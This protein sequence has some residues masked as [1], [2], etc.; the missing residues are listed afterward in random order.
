[1]DQAQC[2][3]RG[4]LF[5]IVTA[6]L[7][8]RCYCYSFIAQLGKLRLREVRNFPEVKPCKVAVRTLRPVCWTVKHGEHFWPLLAGSPSRAGLAGAG[9]G[10]AGL[11]LSA[12]CKGHLKPQSR[13]I[14]L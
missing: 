10:V 4:S 14:I 13:E 3:S 2:S 6:T 1:M 12:K 9:A 11:T 7:Q 5:L 8:G